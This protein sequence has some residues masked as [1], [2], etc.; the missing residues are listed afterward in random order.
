[1]MT[2]RRFVVQ[3]P[4][5]EQEERARLS[6]LLP[7]NGF[8]MADADTIVLLSLQGNKAAARSPVVSSGRFTTRCLPGAAVN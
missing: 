3:L 6:D 2:G 5:I 4:P 8:D 1:M 7:R